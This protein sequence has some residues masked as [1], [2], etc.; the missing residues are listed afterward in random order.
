MPD[1]ELNPD[2]TAVVEARLE[3]GRRIQEQRDKFQRH[4]NRKLERFNREILANN[5]KCTIALAKGLGIAIPTGSHMGM[6]R[7][8]V[9][10]VSWDGPDPRQ[11]KADQVADLSKAVQEITSAEKAL[12]PITPLPVAAAANG[13]GHAH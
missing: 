9:G 12:A 1:I 4:A 5:E 8:G 7:P 11:P 3:V 6:K 13:D 2:L 10:I